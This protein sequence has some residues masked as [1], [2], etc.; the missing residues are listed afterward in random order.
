M[1]KTA[2]ATYTLAVPREQREGQAELKPHGFLK[3]T[4]TGVH[5][6]HDELP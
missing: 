1:S 3:A 5:P 4:G 6:R 2:R